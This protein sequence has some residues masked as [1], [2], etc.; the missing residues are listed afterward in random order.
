MVMASFLANIFHVYVLRLLVWF[1]KMCH[2]F[3]YIPRLPCLVFR[4]FHFSSVFFKTGLFGLLMMSHLFLL[5][6]L[7]FIF[8]F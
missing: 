7:A 2:S 5:E 8:H 6:F 1:F 3:L 4:V